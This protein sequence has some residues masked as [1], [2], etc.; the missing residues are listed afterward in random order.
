MHHPVKHA[1]QTLLTIV[2][3]IRPIATRSIFRNLPL[4]SLNVKDGIPCSNIDTAA[5]RFLFSRACIDRRGRHN[6]IRRVVRPYTRHG[7]IPLLHFCLMESVGDTLFSRYVGLVLRSFR[8]S[9]TADYSKICTL[10]PPQFIHYT[11]AHGHSTSRAFPSSS[12]PGTSP[13]SLHYN[14]P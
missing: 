1:Q 10:L 2:R 13:C 3:S 11:S 14:M 7:A 9:R 5:Q 8:P 12:S 4:Q 6:A